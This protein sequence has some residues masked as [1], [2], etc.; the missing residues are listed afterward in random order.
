MTKTL[1]KLKP[2]TFAPLRNGEPFFIERLCKCRTDFKCKPKCSEWKKIRSSTRTEVLAFNSVIQY[3]NR[4]RP[5]IYKIGIID[6]G[7]AFY[8]ITREV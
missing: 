7:Y 5:E 6:D 1:S 4:Y 3:L 2:E 8:R